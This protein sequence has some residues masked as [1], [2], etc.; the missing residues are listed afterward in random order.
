MCSG[1][2]GASRSGHGRSASPY[3]C[4]SLFIR[5]GRFAEA[6]DELRLALSLEPNNAQA[7][8]FFSIIYLKEK[9]FAAAFAFARCA[10]ASKHSDEKF[11]AHLKNVERLFPTSP[12]QMPPIGG[13]DTVR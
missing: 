2:S 13:D 6:A 12:H 10:V 5:E 9:D 11:Q 1:R 8:Y 3:F 4:S 7:F